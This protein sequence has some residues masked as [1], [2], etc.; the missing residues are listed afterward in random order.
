MLS[1]S[2]FNALLKTLEE[3]PPY[4]KFIF[5]T[6]EI[7]KVPITI[8]SRCIRFDL[9]RVPQRLLAKHLVDIAGREG[10]KLDEVAASLIANAGEGSVRDSL[11]ILDRII[12][13]NNYSEIISEETAVNILGL[14]GK[15]GIY[16]LYESLMAKNVNEVLEK[17]E[18]VYNSL[19]NVNNFLNDLLDITH[20]LLMAKNNAP[21]VNLSSF[22]RTWVEKNRDCLSQS[23]LFRIWQ[24]VIRA[25]DEMRNTGNSRTFLEVLLLKI[26]YGINIPEVNDLIKK[27]KAGGAV[28][29]GAEVKT[30]TE[31]VKK[32]VP[33]VKKEEKDDLANMALSLFEGAKI[34]EENK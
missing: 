23:A 2:A 10:Y 18:K 15:E 7:R 14:G 8:L 21:L 28:G 25:L 3:P 32:D 12:S 22:Q 31:V 4:V 16:G 19:I 1:G 6:T 30:V 24:F 33:I 17:F 5:A 9:E 20:L 29:V 27:I 26:C 34:V 13:F 11:S